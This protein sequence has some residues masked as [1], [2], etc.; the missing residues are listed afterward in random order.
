MGVLPT[1]A[2]RAAALLALAALLGS[3]LLLTAC[4]DGDGS[5]TTSRVAQTSTTPSQQASDTQPATAT[6]TAPAP[7]RE[8]TVYFSSQDGSRLVQ[9]TR[10]VATDGSLVRAALDALAQGPTASGAMPALPA[11]TTV[12][13]TEVN[14]D[15]AVVDLSPEFVAGYPSG[16]AAAEMAVL[17]PLVYTATAV[18]G[19][20]RVRVTVG[21]QAPAPAGSQFDWTGGFTRADFPDM[22]ATP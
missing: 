15:E 3:S 12:V 2:R 20:E 7:E 18:E 14:G 4:G 17:A 11:G 13:A 1:R 22:G 5:S 21:G 19:V 16:G 8:V 10:P 6:T 9:E